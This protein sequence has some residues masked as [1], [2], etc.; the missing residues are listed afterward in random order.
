[1]YSDKSPN[2]SIKETTSKRETNPRL[3]LSNNPCSLAILH[4]ILAVLV[5]CYNW[6]EGVPELR[7]IQLDISAD[8]RT[9]AK[10]SCGCCISGEAGFASDCT[11]IMDSL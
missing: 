2:A 9:E 11:A 6:L 5:K 3:L 4:A 8:P 1:V 7:C 10:R